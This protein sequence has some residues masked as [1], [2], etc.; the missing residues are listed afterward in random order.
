MNGDRVPND[1]LVGAGLKLMRDAGM[2]LER[3]PA[4]GRAM[5]YRLSNGQTVRVR[6]CNDH[7]LVV[8]ADESSETAKLNIEGTDHLLVI[9]PQTPREIT[10]RGIFGSI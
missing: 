1:A 5:I 4:R 10:G 3:A 9:M 8:L 6:T 2:P 7:V